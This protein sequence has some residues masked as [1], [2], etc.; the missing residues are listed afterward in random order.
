MEILHVKKKKCNLHFVALF[1]G[2]ERPKVQTMKLIQLHA[3]ETH[4]LRN[5]Y[6]YMKER[7]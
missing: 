7:I 6:I 4:K 5:I 3:D 2:L 1:S